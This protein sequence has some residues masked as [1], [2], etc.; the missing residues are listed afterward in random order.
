MIKITPD[1]P[2]IHCGACAKACPHLLIG[3]VPVKNGAER[4]GKAYPQGFLR[5]LP[6]LPRLPLGLPRHPAGRSLILL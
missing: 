5:F 2:C 1:F 4:G 3:M 6:V